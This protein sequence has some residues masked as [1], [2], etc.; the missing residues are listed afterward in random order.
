[1]MFQRRPGLVLFSSNLPG[2]HVTLFGPNG[3]LRFRNDA[4]HFDD[5]HRSYTWA[6]EW[7]E[8][9]DNGTQFVF[10]TSERTVVG[11]VMDGDVR[12]IDKRVDVTR[13]ESGKPLQLLADVMDLIQ[14]MTAAGRSTIRPE[15]G[16]VQS[17]GPTVSVLTCTYNRPQML[18][19]AITSLRTQTY[20]SWEQLITDD[21]STDP[22]VKNVLNAAQR[23]DSR[24]RIFQK[25]KNIDQPARY[26]NEMIDRSRGKYI[27]FLDDDN[28]KKEKWAEALV[29]ML[30]ANPDVDMV[31]CGQMIHDKTGNTL[32]SSA[33]LRTEDEVH[34]R[35]TIDTGCFLIRREALEKI[36]YFPLDISTNED[37]AMMRRAAICLS[38][39][40]LPDALGVY[41]SHVG[42][43]M[44]RCEALGNTRDQ[45]KI[46]ASV[47]ALSYGVRVYTAPYERLTASQRD[48][49]EGV[50]GGVEAI[51]WVEEGSDLAMIMMPFQMDR[52]EAEEIAMRH[53]AVVTVHSEDPYALAPNIE[54]VVAMKER[55]GNVWVATN[56]SACVGLYEEVVGQGKVLV[57]PSLSIDGRVTVNI[58]EKRMHDV[59]LV[60]YAYPRRVEFVKEFLRYFDK[61][62]LR[63]RG[64]GWKEAGFEAAESTASFGETAAEYANARAVIC[65][66]RQHGDCCDGPHEPR[67]VARGYV[68]G[69]GGARVFIDGTRPDHAFETGEVE[70]FYDPVDLA[71]KLLRYLSFEESV[72]RLLAEPLR[73]R[74]WRDF[75]YRT[76]M[77]RVINSVRSPRYGAVIP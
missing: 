60:G 57:C 68:E 47:W 52:G 41:R 26:W 58:S 20:E 37:W 4:S 28:L 61:G 40:H 69:M 36:G 23:L 6:F 2:S 25:T 63:I 29:G 74:A 56:D 35:N 48:V 64:D 39:M 22:A 34:Q 1:M 42:Q 43:R 14:K 21:A 10:A 38:M 49:V 65:L 30:D 12:V 77:A 5:V 3:K 73:E 31:T 55:C 59:V 27:G 53:H 72:Q 46:R 45:E 44:E 15:T 11:E 66:H 33:N 71:A 16:E 62:R 24:I 54:R 75:T 76:R 7:T 51:P 50:R 32:E 13:D 70:W 19:E 8:S 9:F 17:S 18:L 67:L